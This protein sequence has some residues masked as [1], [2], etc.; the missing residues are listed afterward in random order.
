[1]SRACALALPPSTVVPRGLL[2]PNGLGELLVDRSQACPAQLT[3]LAQHTHPEGPSTGC[4][5]L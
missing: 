1:M 3:P 4:A 5:G 2:T